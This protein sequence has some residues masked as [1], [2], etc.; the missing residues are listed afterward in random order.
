MSTKWF[1]LFTAVAIG[2]TI[3]IPAAG[4]YGREGGTSKIIAATTVTRTCPNPECK[5]TAKYVV[6][7]ANDSVV[8]TGCGWEIKP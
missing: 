7:D 4:N 2:A 6:S 5:K 1:I 3:S 8:C